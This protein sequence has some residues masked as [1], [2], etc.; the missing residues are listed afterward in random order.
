VKQLQIL[1]AFALSGAASTG[2]IVVY[3]LGGH[4]QLEGVFLALALG[5]LGIGLGLWG[6]ALTPPDGAVEPVEPLGE[7]EVRDEAVEALVREEVRLPRRRF[8][9]AGLAGAIGAF[10]LALL[11]PLRSL[12]PAVGRRL[13]ETSWGPGLRLVTPEGEAVRVDDVDVGGVL[14]VYP[15][16]HVAAADSQVLLIRLEPGRYRPLPGRED[17]APD[18][19]V[20]F[21]KVCT[22]AGC[23]VG[24]YDA[25]AHRLVCPCHYATFDVLDACRPVFGPARRPLPQLPL[26]VD[27]DGFLR[28]RDDFD[29]P[30]GPGFWTWGREPAG[31]EVDGP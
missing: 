9:L 31:G 22:H 30:V 25:D 15:E 19:L 2:F 1:G 21:S 24:L 13:H 27:G 8:L 18:D 16:G 10:G 3:V 12:G 7:P 17:W 20:A 26:E 11:L 6:K 4:T 28:A 29:E 14:T 5:G 23:P